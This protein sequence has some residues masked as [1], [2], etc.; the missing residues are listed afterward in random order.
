MR[1]ARFRKQGNWSSWSTL[2]KN[3]TARF[4]PL[5]LTAD[6]SGK[7]MHRPLQLWEK[8]VWQGSEKPETKEITSEDFE[9]M[10]EQ[11]RPWR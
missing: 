8:N 9:S 7:G 6:H 4:S 2:K 11:P 10:E 5:G 1:E 3:S